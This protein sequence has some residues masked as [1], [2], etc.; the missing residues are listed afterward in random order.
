M[1]KSGHYSEQNLHQIFFISE[2]LVWHHAELQKIRGF[3][4]SSRAL[5]KRAYLV[6]I[7]D[8]FLLFLHK[9]IPML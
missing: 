2:W 7:R 3:A 9:N 6:I 1:E 4:D 8:I 5:D